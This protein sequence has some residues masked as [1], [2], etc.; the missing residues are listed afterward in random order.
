MILSV[1]A[2]QAEVIRHA[3]P[4]NLCC[5]LLDPAPRR[6][7]RPDHR[8]A[9]VPVDPRRPVSPAGVLRQHGVLPL[10]KEPGPPEQPAPD[11]GPSVNLQ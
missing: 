11:A 7:H 6:L 5:R 1:T 8:P 4:A 10:V 3:A 9:G 2:Q